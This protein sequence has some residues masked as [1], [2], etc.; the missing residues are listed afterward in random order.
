MTD[1]PSPLQQPKE[2]PV[3]SSSGELSVQDVRQVR[4]GSQESQGSSPPRDPARPPRPEDLLE[5]VPLKTPSL[6]GLLPEVPAK[7]PRRWGRRLLRLIL[8]LA[9]P[10]ALI[11]LVLVLPERDLPDPPSGAL[12][13]LVEAGSVWQYLDDGSDPGPDWMQESF[14]ASDWATGN[15][16]FGYGKGDETT[17]IRCR[18]DWPVGEPCPEGG[19]PDRTMTHYFR[20]SFQVDDPSTFERARISLL[21]DDGALV[22]LNGEQV[23]RANMAL[24]VSGHGEPAAGATEHKRSFFDYHLDLRK[25]KA[26]ANLLAVE[27]HQVSPAGKDMG[28]DLK[29]LA[30]DLQAR[31]V[32]RGPYLQMVTPDSAVIRWRTADRVTTAL[33]WGDGAGN[34]A[35]TQLHSEGRLSRNHRV[36]LT[37][38]EP[39]T[40]YAYRLGAEAD[41]LGDEIFHFRTAPEDPEQNVHIWA[42]GDQGTGDSLARKVKL[43][44]LNH[45]KPSGRTAPDVWITLGDNAYDD[46]TEEEFR[47]AFFETYG[48]LI[49]HTAMWPSLG[50]HDLKSVKDGKGPYFDIFDLPTDG[51]AGG[52]PSGT[53]TYYSFDRGPVHFIA[54]N[55]ASGD[56]RPGREMLSW[57]EKDLERNVRPWV[58]AYFHH[59]P[60]TDGWH[61]SD[62]PK[63]GWRMTA[64]RENALP[65]LEKAGVDLV[66]AGH[67]HSY[68]RSYFLHRHYG[69]SDTL[70]DAMKLAPG[71][72]DPAGDGPYTKRPDGPGTVYVVAGSSGKLATG[73]L[74]HPAMLKNAEVLGSM[75]IEIE[76]RNLDAYFITDEGEVLDH[77]RIV[78]R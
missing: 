16:L 55:T 12:V 20:H 45:V 33:R 29:V 2:S 35:P 50:N 1:E 67:S 14:D 58:I 4:Q 51:E 75:I 18:P 15:G 23:A 72:G 69:T 53:E 48:E 9:V 11:G 76:G 70:T 43:A 59:P 7:K 30:F 78:H 10:A 64:V 37:D 66:I 34:E 39:D 49:T 73:R 54:L 26:G 52:E 19:E 56:L 25:V 65:I 63:K 62:D 27:L 24:G 68:E 21:R 8:I 6:D 17:V 36:R 31:A 41:R 74:E 46:G 32:T 3:D 42:I 38:L 13:T 47:R 22:Y 77:F 44:Y 61:K 28:F 60:Y 71:D 40:D 57:L 5:E